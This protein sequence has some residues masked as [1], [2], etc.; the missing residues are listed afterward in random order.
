MAGVEQITVEQGEA[1]MRLDRW[2]K[3]HF[4][5]LG[6]GH[7]QKLLRSGQIRVDGGRAKTDTRLEPGQVVRV[8]PLGVDR[9][10]DEPLTAKSIRSQ[11]D[12]SVL[13]K[14]M[15]YEDPSVFVFNKPSGL[16][17]QGGSG[18]VRHVDDMLEAFRNKKGEKPRLVHRLDRDT[19]G[20]L[21]VAR[22]RLAAMKLA[23]AFRGRDAQK[24]YWALVK[25]VPKKREGRISTWLV[26][27]QTPDGDRV[28][29]AKHGEDGADHAV[30]NYRIVDQAGQSLT[31]LEMEPHTGRT[32][33]LRVHAAHIGCPI[34]G[35]PKYFEAD[36]NW[37][38]PGGIQN[39]L[40]LH[41][42]R[43]VIPHPDGKG[44][45]DITAPLPPHMRQSWNLLGFDEATAEEE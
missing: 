10:G 23:E 43:I 19:S 31:W 15:L 27:E 44:V 12:G 2:F 36:T 35:D 6:F 30:S 25:G 14:M 5:G 1:G 20:V 21:V 18:V 34:I 26:K 42:R 16:A 41:A 22:S 7:L 17:V 37:E 11:D 40:H 8:P 24:T 45:I 4:P 13:R 38:F 33:Q 39:R 32:H 29:I 28:R 3:T 9:K